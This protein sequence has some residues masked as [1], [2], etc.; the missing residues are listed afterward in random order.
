MTFAQ[1]YNDPYNTT[2]GIIQETKISE[3]LLQSI[4]STSCKLNSGKLD[5]QYTQ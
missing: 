2:D 1:D 5:L 3:Y 4:L